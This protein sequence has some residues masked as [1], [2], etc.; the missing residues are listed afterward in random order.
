LGYKHAF[1]RI[2]VMAAIIGLGLSFLLVPIYEDLGA[3]ITL[4]IVEVFVTV[5]MYFYLKIKL[6]VVQ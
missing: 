3:A 4:L 5:V 1:S 2:L 6:K